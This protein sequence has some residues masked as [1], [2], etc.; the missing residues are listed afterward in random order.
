MNDLQIAGLMAY[1]VKK[2]WKNQAKKQITSESSWEVNGCKRQEAEEHAK[3]ISINHE[4]N[5][6]GKNGKPRNVEGFMEDPFIKTYKQRTDSIRGGN[7]SNLRWRCNEK[8]AM[9]KDGIH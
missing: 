5:G 8:V 4:M 2:V 1:R 7:V 3:R 6:M 9:S